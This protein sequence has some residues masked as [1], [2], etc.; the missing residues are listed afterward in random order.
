MTTTKLVPS[1]K[2][3][4]GDDIVEVISEGDFIP[5]DAQIVV[6]EVR[7]NRVLVA[8]VDD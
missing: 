8:A 2:A 6:S 5:K 1:G 4:F 3:R 7:G